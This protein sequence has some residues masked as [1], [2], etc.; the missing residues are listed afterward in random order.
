MKKKIFFPF[1]A[2]VVFYYIFLGFYIGGFI[3]FITLSIVSRLSEIDVKDLIGMFICLVVALYM[4]LGYFL[5][6]IV[7]NEEHVYVPHSFR[8]KKYRLQHTVKI[9][10]TEIIDI[11]FIRAIKNSKNKVVVG[12]DTIPFYHQ[13]MLITL[14]SGKKERIL[15]D[16][17]SKKQKRKIL[18][19]LNKR[20]QNCGN[21]IDITSAKE[22]LEKLKMA[23]SGLYVGIMDST[24]RKK[25]KKIKDNKKTDENEFK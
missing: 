12:E 9:K 10:Y 7:F 22:S 13:Y 6:R 21:I 23:C 5:H 18:N 11:L 17:F 19:E 16:F 1:G 8:P 3:W 24:G 4:I 15:V 14:R 25:N 20:M 2:L